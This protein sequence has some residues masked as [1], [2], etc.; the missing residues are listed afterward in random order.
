MTKSASIAILSIICVIAL[1]LGVFAC[2]PGGLEFGEFSVYNSAISL[3]QGDSI[4]TDSVVAT[5]KVKLDEEADVNDVV[6]VLKSRL[7]NMYGRYFCNVVAN[8]DNTISITVPK[9]VKDSNTSETSILSAVTSTGKVEILTESTYSEDDVL[10]TSEHVS[11]MTT[12]RYASGSTTYYIVNITLTKEGKAIASE[13]LT[14]SS[15]SWS[16]YCAVDGTV[17]YGIAYTSNGGLQLYANS[18]DDAQY[19]TGLIKSGALS[20]KLTALDNEEKTTIG[21]LI[22]A[23]LVAVIVVCNWLFYVYK[24]R[25]LAIV[26]IASQLVAIVVFIFFAGG[27]YFNLLNVASAIGIVLGYGLMSY[28][29]IATF[30]KMVAYLQEKTVAASRYKAFT[31][32]NVRNVVVHA[33]VLVLGIV[34]WLIP[35]G[36]TAPLGNAL[37]YC[38]V[39][40]FVVTMG[41]NRL[42]AS[43]NL[44]LEGAR[45]K[46]IAK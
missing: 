7:G 43:F 18:E 40:S 13:N 23:I 8:E 37:V 11:R 46:K 3:I 14:E 27:V 44:G 4:F 45:S 24:Y 1:V 38:S 26:P 36:V 29:C 20:A 32:L 22:F 5:Y 2:L 28:F 6:S 33:A 19:I 42:F 35:T 15:S 10:L 39:L 34:L 16:A 17:A 30:D 41:L 21:G 31:E 9:T 12:R 25:K